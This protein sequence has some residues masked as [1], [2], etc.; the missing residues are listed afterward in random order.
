[1]LNENLEGNI[2]E[3]WW[4]CFELFKRIFVI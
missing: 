1:V 2:N 4:I 3:I